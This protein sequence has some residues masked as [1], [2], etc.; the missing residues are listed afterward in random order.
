[1]NFSPPPL[2]LL[3]RASAGVSAPP[4]VAAAP[5][6]APSLPVSRFKAPQLPATRRPI[7]AKN[8]RIMLLDDLVDGFDNIVEQA[9]DWVSNE[10][11]DAGSGD[12]VSVPEFGGYNVPTF[13][14]SAYASGVPPEQL[15]NS[16]SVSMRDVI[17]GMCAWAA[18]IPI[19]G[20]YI[21]SLCYL[22]KK[23]AEGLGGE[24]QTLNCPAGK[25]PYNGECVDQFATTPCD[26]GRGYVDPVDGTCIQCGP[27]YSFD[28]T[29]H[30]CIEGCPPETPVSNARWGCVAANYNQPCTVDGQKGVIAPNGDCSP[31]GCG[32]GLK[33]NLDT[34]SCE[35]DSSEVPPK[36]G[37]DYCSE[38]GAKYEPYFDN[39]SRQWACAEKCHP[40]EMR[41]SSGY[42]VCKPGLSRQNPGDN[43]SPCV[44][45][46][47][48]SVKTECGP[49]QKLDPGTGVCIEDKEQAC[50]E[51][52]ERDATGKCRPKKND[53]TTKEKSDG[54]PWGIALGLSLLGV[55][56][57]VVATSMK[58]PEQKKIDERVEQLKAQGMSEQ[59]ARAQ[60]EQEAADAKRDVSFPSGDTSLQ[61]E[62]RQPNPKRGGKGKSKGKKKSLP[63]H[64]RLAMRPLVYALGIAGLGA[65]AVGLWPKKRPSAGSGDGVSFSGLSAERQAILQEAL[66]QE[67]VYYQ[68]GGGHM[69]DKGYGVDC[70]GLIIR[71]HQRAGQPLPPCPMPTSNGWWQCLQRIDVPEPGDLA[72]YGNQGQ[73][74]AVHVEMVLSW[75]GDHA[76]TLGAIGDRDV[77]SLEIAKARNAIVKRVSTEGRKSFL[78]FVKN[79]IEEQAAKIN[80]G[81][82]IEPVSTALLQQ[83]EA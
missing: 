9:K 40:D 29:S 83:D 54:F 73:D 65:L 47:K 62:Q 37:P 12:Q 24:S 7:K 61:G 80:E 67:G 6:A 82:P 32:P 74:R 59:D 68:W 36:P 60:A 81:A 14:A 23:A 38:F 1:M 64:S 17:L 5:W 26:G 15:V 63:A 27:G 76:L 22:I 78:G 42:C 51:G 11:S 21:V 25:M 31:D 3:R 75:E 53:S 52:Q 34:D 48:P 20:L 72:L 39:A 10:K 28:P 18:G 66:A 71:A 13:V 79:P 57:V 70:S 58:S 33:Y 35:P 43:T 19:I 77:V 46:K 69:G 44:A 49:G 55:A 50:P 45:S 4:A 2:P 8:V 16:L 56:G 41:D 30:V